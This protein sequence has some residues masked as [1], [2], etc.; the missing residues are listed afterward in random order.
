MGAAPLGFLVGNRVNAAVGL[1]EGIGIV[2]TVG[3]C[4]CDGAAVVKVEGR[5]VKRPGLSADEY[6]YE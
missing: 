4:N 5:A 1:S 3:T 2:G 6:E